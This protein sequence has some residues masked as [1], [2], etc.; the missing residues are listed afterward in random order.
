M[1]EEPLFTLLETSHPASIHQSPRTDPTSVGQTQG[2]QNAYEW[3]ILE[4][5]ACETD[6]WDGTDLNSGYCGNFGFH[7][8]S[9]R[10][11]YCASSFEGARLALERVCLPLPFLEVIWLC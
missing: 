9:D 10:P 2:D 1:L 4:G 3:L 6:V 5:S 7:S 8:Y 11:S